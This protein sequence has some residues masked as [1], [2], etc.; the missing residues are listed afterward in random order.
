MTAQPVT[1]AELAVAF[2]R[3]LATNKRAAAET[4]YALALRYRNQDVNGRRRFDL[5]KEWATRA[6]ALLDDLPSDTPNPVDQLPLGVLRRP[7]RPLTHRQH[8]RQHHPLHLGQIHSPTK[9][10]RLQEVAASTMVLVDDT[11][12]GDIA[13]HPATTGSP[14][15]IVV[16]TS[17][18]SPH[19]CNMP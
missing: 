16:N 4:A 13:V 14:D 5:A 15:P 1:V 6:V 12:S 10:Y 9:R 2:K 8:R 17:S 19:F 11:S 18:D 3:E 7:P